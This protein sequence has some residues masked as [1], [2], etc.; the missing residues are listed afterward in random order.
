MCYERN[1]H[2]R[3]VVIKTSLRRVSVISSYETTT[4]S[5]SKAISARMLST[6]KQDLERLLRTCHT[7]AFT[8]VITPVL[9]PGG[10]VWLTCLS[11]YLCNSIR[12]FHIARQAVS[13]DRVSRNH[14][15]HFH[16]LTSSHEQPCNIAKEY[17]VLWMYTHILLCLCTTWLPRAEGP[18]PFVTSS[19]YFTN[20]GATRI[21]LLYFE[22]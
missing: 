21:C 15:T 16:L 20:A 18:R 3:S 5:N 10:G 9:S 4:Q 12:Q 13:A 14:H 2:M 1:I 17:T 7:R 11:D 6:A 19:T 22:L 8:S